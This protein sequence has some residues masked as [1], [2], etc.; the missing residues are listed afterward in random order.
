MPNKRPRGPLKKNG[1]VPITLGR[2]LVLE[3]TF[4]EI[5]QGAQGRKRVSAYLIV[6]ND[7]TEVILERGQDSDYCHGIELWQCAKQ[8]GLIGQGIRTDRELKGLQQDSFCFIG[9]GHGR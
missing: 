9:H 5:D 4:H 2:K 1:S 6:V 3:F 8:E 7:E